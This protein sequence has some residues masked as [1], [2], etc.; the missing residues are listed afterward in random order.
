MSVRETGTGGSGS[1]DGREAYLVRV[2]DQFGNET[3]FPIV[4]VS[5]CVHIL[6]YKIAVK[7]NFVS[8][9]LQTSSSRNISLLE[10]A[11]SEVSISYAIVTEDSVSEYSPPQNICVL[12]PPGSSASLAMRCV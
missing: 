2:Q 1:G 3:Y 12:L 5:V 9:L 4:H 8:P 7:Y 11:C 6:M 10:F